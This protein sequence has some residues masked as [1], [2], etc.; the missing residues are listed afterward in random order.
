M[1]TSFFS[2]ALALAFAAPLTAAPV[3]SE[4]LADNDGG[5]K[6][7]DGEDQDWIEI[8]NPDVNPVD[9]AGWRLTDDPLK[10]SKWVFPSRVLAPGARLIVWASEK[11]RTPA[12]GNLHTN[13]QLD[14]DGEYLALLS[15]AGTVST[16]FSP[17]YPYQSKN[18]SYGSGF[19]GT[20]TVT[21]GTPTLFTGGTN[22]S[23]VKLNGVGA[24]VQDSNS[25]NIFDDTLAQPQHQQY[26]WYDYSS[27]LGAI[28]AGQQIADATL[29]WTGESK[30]FA[31]VS[32]LSTI[33]TPVGIFI[34]PNDNNRGITAIA[35]GADGNDLVDFY[36]GN[37]RYS[38]ITIQQGET[39]NFTWNVTQLV[40]DWLAN[41]GAGNYGKFLVVPGA[42]P[43]WVAWDQNRP[44]P[45][46]TIR[47]VV[48]NPPAF[49]TGFMTPSPGTV[50]GSTTP[51]GPLVREVT[52]NPAQPAAGNAFPVTARI[53]P[54]QGG[55]LTTLSLIYRR[56]YE[57]EATVPMVDNGTNGDVTS[58]DGIYTGL[59][60][61]SAMT[62]GQMIRWKVLASDASIYTTLMPPYRDTLDSPQYFGT[63]P[64]DPSIA[65][66]FMVVHRF[67]QVPG[68]ANNATG[69][70]CSIFMN[71]EFYDNAGINLHGQSTSG[72]AFLKKSYDIDGTRGYRFKWTTDPSQPRAKDINLLTIYADKTKIRH[73]LAYEMNRE[74]GVAAH[75]CFAVHCRLN[76]VF[77][78][79]YDFIEDGDDV[80]LE[81]AGLNKNGVLYKAYTNMADPATGANP[82]AGNTGGVEKKSRKNENNLDLYNFLQGMHLTDANARKAFLFDNVDVP[83]MINFMAANTVTGNVDLHAKNYYIY[84][85]TGKT[86]LWTL[87][88]WDQDLSQGRLWTSVN[89]YF[90]DGMYLNSG[91][92]LSGQG[93]SLVSRMYGVPEFSNMAR[94]RIRSLQDKFWKTSAAAPDLTRWYDRRVS[95]LAAQFGA[96]LTVGQ[97]DTP[98][99]DAALDYAKYPAAAWK[100]AGVATASPFAAYTM[101]QEIQRVMSSYVVQRIN[102]INVD[103]QV[104]PAY[105][106]SA[107][108]PLTF[109]ALDHSPA[110]GDQDQEFI[111]I[112]NPNSVAID[113]SGWR[114][115]GG[116]TFT[117]EPGT[118]VNGTVGTGVALP[119]GSNKIYVVASRNGFKTRTVAPKGGQSLNVAGGYQGHLS[120]IGETL[121]LLDDAGTQRATT[122][123][124]GSA[125]PPQQYLVISEIMY[126]PGGNGL[127][128]F[129]ELTNISSSVTLDLTGVHFNTG[130]EF[131]FTG[132]AVT[133]LAPGA[134]VLVVRDMAAFTA[135]Y[136]NG[137]SIAGV[138]ANG[139]AL[140]NGGEEIKLEDA[141]NNTIKNFT[142]DDDLPWPPA[143]ANG[144]SLVL[145]R[146]QTNPDPSLYQNWRSSTAAGGNPGSTDELHFTGNAADDIDKDGLTALVE[147]A[148][149]TSDTNAGSVD[150]HPARG[151]D[152]GVPFLE[153]TISRRLNADDAVFAVESSANGTAWSSSGWAP[154]SSS[155]VAGGTITEVW[156]L[157]GTPAAGAHLLVRCK[158]THL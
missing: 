31:G 151:T 1:K 118:I 71:G 69:T 126:N 113:L 97:N 49:V 158:C 72:G 121:N 66:P 42:H 96:T 19:G 127:A 58:G 68:N 88:P 99:T 59:I 104:P 123:Y 14:Q 73:G 2:F 131:S 64:A 67:I 153:I 83:K 9:L 107:Q 74:A 138:F 117:F 23:R 48:A 108:A 54:L 112:T 40:K 106:L 47:T 80:Y 13:F 130:I 125:T 91:G 152:A 51:A 116:I 143:G 15:P 32:G 128:E 82:A 35:T 36:A 95:E 24:A 84:C 119:A 87:L 22:Y 57:T 12:S 85:D 157:T 86:N 29:E 77:D 145:I 27:R 60:P 141:S 139:S 135:A 45:K 70:R 76:G 25:L 7:E 44:G 53:Q 94:R 149:G 6:D 39:K 101:S 38:T 129:I 144:A 92:T 52:E 75:Y 124:T 37:S 43:S 134:K 20:V 34:Q 154:V 110:G 120:N 142:F 79:I 114:I 61:G 65:T 26:L 16:E 136:G 17:V 103:T 21:D 18:V 30:L 132:S 133:S 102:T 33:T 100:N 98:G 146:P 56:G 148:L 3:I 147:Y 11:D 155:P 140:N 63:V 28:P 41:P 90:D 109:S 115:T 156:R 46:L 5:F 10:P 50:N 62:A 137:H 8:H 55:A 150:L 4:F 81:R 78:G 93:Q 111:E 89:N 122:T 105:N